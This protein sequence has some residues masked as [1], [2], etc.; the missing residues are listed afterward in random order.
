MEIAKDSVANSPGSSVL[1]PFFSSASDNSNLSNTITMDVYGIQTPDFFNGLKE[2]TGNFKGESSAG[3]YHSGIV[4]TAAPFESVKEAVSKFGRIV[5]WKAHKAMAVERQ[6]NVQSE[7]RKAQEEIP[8]YRKQSERAEVL[9][10]QA[11]KELDKT[12]RMVEELKLKLEKA[13]TEETQAKQDSELAVLRAKEMEQ[14]IGD[15][16]SVAAKTQ[17]EVAKA[18]HE[19]AVTDLISVKKELEELKGEYVVLVKERDSAVKKAEMAVA[20]LRQIEKTV[21]DLTLE[22]ITTK[23]SLESA[24]ASHLEAEESRIAAA[25]AMEQDS[26]SWEKELKKAED[27]LMQLNEQLSLSKNLKLKLDTSSALLLNL[28]AEL[29][30]YMEAKLHEENSPGI[31][32]QEAVVSIRKELE[33]VKQTVEKAKEEAECLRVAASC[34]KSEIE[35]EKEALSIL[36]RKEEM[37]S[38]AISSL[39][40]ELKKTST[41][42]ELALSKGKEFKNEILELPSLL[43]QAT[44][45]ADQA[46][47]FAALAREELEKAKEEAQHAK[48]Q[49][50]TVSIRLD[51]ALKE[52]EASKASESLAVAATKALEESENNASKSCDI[53]ND[54]VSLSFEEYRALSEKA[55]EAEDMANKKIILAI[56][57]IKEAKVSESVSLAKLE[58]LTE[59]LNNKKEALRVAIEEA[60][61]AQEGKLSVEQELRTWRAEHEQRRK[62]SDASFLSQSVEESGGP[63]SYVEEEI[64]DSAN[65]ATYPK[66][67]ISENN[68]RSSKS[69]AKM[70]KKKSFFPRIVM[71]LARKKAQSLK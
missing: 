18:R 9:K 37:S 63:N 17:L 55:R 47:G 61:K 68:T 71:F 62:A 54:S 29:A 35:S 69:E 23:E 51:A 22:L 3:M 26:Q 33:E 39:E 11:L 56:E 66:L 10:E 58:E 40:S 42:L 41:E 25:L 53:T 21:E 28:K 24:H 31:S 65:S 5:D 59:E 50:S 14:G 45:E 44:Q 15:D 1:N 6:K 16:V 19:A 46:K 60:E 64:I 2:D 20:D 48:A 8:M 32:T 27:E 38:I 7:L 4:D 49:A 30:T 43:Q 67:Y 36:K 70:K 57:Q 13:L 12:K 52:V 34:L